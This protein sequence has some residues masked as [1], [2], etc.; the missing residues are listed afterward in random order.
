VNRYAVVTILQAHSQEDAHNRVVARGRKSDS[1][2]YVGRAVPV[3]RGIEYST[4]M[5]GVNVD[6]KNH[7]CR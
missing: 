1:I 5:V 7:V 4:T 3:P 2:L 6:G